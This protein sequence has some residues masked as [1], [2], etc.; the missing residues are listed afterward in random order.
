MIVCRFQFLRA[1]SEPSSL[2]D[3]KLLYQTV[4]ELLRDFLSSESICSFMSFR[5]A[6]NFVSSAVEKFR[7][8]VLTVMHSPPPLVSVCYRP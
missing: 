5:E 7:G 3:V 2:R 8:G 6:L 4:G 1:L